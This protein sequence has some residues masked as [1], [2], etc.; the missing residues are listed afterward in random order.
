MK[1]PITVMKIGAGHYEASALVV[2]TG[3]GEFYDHCQFWG[4]QKREIPKLYR[5]R[6]AEKGYKLAI[7]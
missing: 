6:L 5:M 1:A 4:Y 3:Y 7:L 2:E